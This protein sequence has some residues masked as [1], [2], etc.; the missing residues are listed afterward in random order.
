[1]EDDDEKTE[2]D[3]EEAD[4]DDDDDGGRTR[5]RRGE[6]EGVGGGGGPQP[7]FNCAP[8]PA[9]GSCF[10]PK[11]PNLPSEPQADCAL[12]LFVPQVDKVWPVRNSFQVKTMC[13]GA[14][15]VANS[16]PSRNQGA[17]LRAS[18]ARVPRGTTPAT[19]EGKDS[20]APHQQGRG[21]KNGS[22]VF[23]PPP[24]RPLAPLALSPPSP[25]LP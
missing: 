18:G 9:S 23:R 3:E 21:K 5:R 19:R 22:E 12:S 25:L 4:I 20:E 7:S 24:R 17:W 13:A 10:L 6:S 11:K 1:M 2:A 14:R 16:P 15:V 8:S